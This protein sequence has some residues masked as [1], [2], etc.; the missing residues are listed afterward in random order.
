MHQPMLNEYIELQPLPMN[1]LCNSGNGLLNPM[2]E[3]Q[4]ILFKL[5]G[6]KSLFFS[7]CFS[8]FT[9]FKT[10]NFWS[11]CTT[12]VDLYD[13]VITISLFYMIN[14]PFNYTWVDRIVAMIVQYVYGWLNV[15]ANSQIPSI[16]FSVF[17]FNRMFFSMD[18]TQYD[19]TTF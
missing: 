2:N 16:H 10:I 12:Y 15:S 6:N 18:H 11:L 3:F 14:Q 19:P 5:L 8:D 13:L 17:W 9:I 4:I 7:V 1:R